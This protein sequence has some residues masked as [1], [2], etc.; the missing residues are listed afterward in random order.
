MKLAQNVGGIDKILRIVLGVAAM[1]GGIYTQT[2]WLVGVGALIALTGLLG[3]CGL[4]YLFGI[5]T[6]PV[7]K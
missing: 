7:K 2:W 5:N 4:Y 6:C 1:G 3:R